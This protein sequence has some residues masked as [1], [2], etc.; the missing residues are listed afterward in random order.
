MKIPYLKINFTIQADEDLFLPQFK[1][2]TFRGV[3]GSTFK[4]LVCAIKGEICTRCLLKKTCIY[5]YIFETAAEEG[6]EVMN[7]EKYSDVPRPFIIEPPL[8]NG[9]TYQKGETLSFSLIVIGKAVQYLPYF[10]YTFDQCGNIGIGK[11]KGKFILK[12]V[13]K[14]NELIYS[15]NIEE[16]KK[17][18][19]DEIEIPEDLDFDGEEKEITL[20]LITPTRIKHN[21]QFSSKLEFYIL[22]KAILFRI[23]FLHYFHVEQRESTWEYSKI[24]ENARKIQIKEDNTYWRDWTRYSSRQ[25]TRM[26]LGG[27][28]GNITYSGNLSPFDQYL[29]AAELFHVGKGTSFGLGKIAIKEVR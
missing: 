24:I 15:N 19:I 3:F 18:A 14:G 25:K 26:K 23:N 1:G 4:K 9:R 5:A 8:E 28:C 21:R 2:S 12:E 16:I 13:T 22:M 27:I 6:Q 29:K 11:G 20:K 17:V 7:I 10:I